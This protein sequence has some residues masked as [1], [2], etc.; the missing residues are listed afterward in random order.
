M[1][2]CPS[3][4]ANLYAYT[5]TTAHEEALVLTKEWDP[6]RMLLSTIP[7]DSYGMNE[8]SGT[9][10]F[11]GGIRQVPKSRTS[12]QKIFSLSSKKSS[13]LSQHSPVAWDRVYDRGERSDHYDLDSDMCLSDAQ[14]AVNT[15]ENGQ[16][17]NLMSSSFLW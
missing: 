10:D 16:H 13:L 1:G 6:R 2:A 5:R 11:S 15:D 8:Q 4:K 3:D 12:D 14:E 9:D 7:E 17:K